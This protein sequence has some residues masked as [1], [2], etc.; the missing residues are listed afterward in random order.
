MSKSIVR[1]IKNVTNGYTSAQVKV[2]NAT[3][4]DTWGPSGVDMDEIA[5]LTYDSAT[6]LEIM[7]MI[8][9]RLNDKGK[10]WRHVLKALMLLDYCL[11]VGSEN[12]VRWSKD[13]LY[14][15]KTLREFQ[16][17]DEENHDQ[18]LAVRTKAKELTSFLNDDERIRT[19][20]ANRHLMRE[21]MSRPGD[22][23]FRGSG[24]SPIRPGRSERERGNG[25]G[26]GRS[27][28]NTGANDREDSDLRRAIEESKISAREDER[29]RIVRASG[30][31]DSADYSNGDI[32][33]ANGN[34]IQSGISRPNT[35][36]ASVDSA[37]LIDF[38]EDESQ[39]QSQYLT[40]YNTGAVGQVS[41]QYTGSV[42]SGT[43][44]GTISPAGVISPMYTGIYQQPQQTGIVYQQQTGYQQP[45][46][47]GYQ[48]TQATGYQQPQATGFQQPQATG[49]Q[50]Q[51]QQQTQSQTQQPQ[52]TVAIPQATGLA[53]QSN[54]LMQQP[55]GITYQ[56]TGFAQQPQF[57][58]YG[59]GGY[60][61][62]Q[63]QPSS[64]APIPT[65]YQSN[66]AYISQQQQQ[67][68]YLPHV[69]SPLA[70]QQTGVNNP[71]RQQ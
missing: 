14:V 25:S 50:F 13:N 71:F 20:R 47:T 11:H 59:F 43:P 57:T 3:S 5:Q 56:Q 29:R 55:T 58:G 44:M 6:F 39:Q 30:E 35:Q 7:D 46:A 32:G 38:G 19:A 69:S 70:P 53:S 60:S 26:G 4:N 15:I 42:S 31:Y 17:I 65:G 36:S 54:G 52:T 48:Q 28:R 24:S 49:Y 2:R 66:Q 63:Q 68:Q 1:S 8:D 16:Y 51:Q 37:N 61:S 21:R 64:L 34:N 67:Q 62:Q 40:V 9:R 45:Q 18:G 27:R 41:P 23:M 10:N 12:C 33:N 22:D